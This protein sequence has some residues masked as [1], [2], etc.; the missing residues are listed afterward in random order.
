MSRYSAG[1]D[2]EDTMDE[3]NETAATGSGDRSTTRTPRWVKAFGIVLAVL[4]V[5][6]IAGLLIGG[7]HG[8]GRH[9]PSSGPT[10]S[11]S[12]EDTPPPGEDG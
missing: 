4:V 2:P 6:F 10:S 3:D 12:T 5:I 11:A 9:L 1:S 8:P 7:G